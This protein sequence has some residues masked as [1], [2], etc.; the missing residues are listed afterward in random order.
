MNDL[1]DLRLHHIAQEIYRQQMLQRLPGKFVSLI[2]N[3]R[4]A[5]SKYN[6]I[7][8]HNICCP[9]ENPRRKSIINLPSIST[10]HYF[11]NRTTIDFIS[12]LIVSF[13]PSL[14]NRIGMIWSPNLPIPKQIKFNTTERCV[15]GLSEENF[16]SKKLYLY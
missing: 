15:Y 13:S 10:C 11:V 7:A 8:M 9:F 12:L 2:S 16:E 14:F 6:L 5:L 1:V 3:S 4:F